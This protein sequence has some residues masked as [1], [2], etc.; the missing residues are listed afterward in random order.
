MKDD[1][2]LGEDSGSF[3]LEPRWLQAK[4]SF[5]PV[6]DKNSY[7][8]AADLLREDGKYAVRMTMDGKPYGTYPFVVKNGRIEFQGRQVRARYRSD[9]LYR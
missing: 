1:K 3:N 2:L 7:I 6:G 9:A 5:H 4:V 8:K